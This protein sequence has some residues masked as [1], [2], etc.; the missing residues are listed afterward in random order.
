MRYYESLDKDGKP[1]RPVYIYCTHADTD[2]VKDCEQKI[3]TGTVREHWK[4]AHG[5]PKEDE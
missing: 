3:K 2:G 5:E 1:I 4:K